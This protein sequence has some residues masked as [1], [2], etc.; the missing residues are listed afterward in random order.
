M[1]RVFVPVLPALFAS[2]GYDAVSVT[3][4]AVAEVMV[5]LHE[6][7][8]VDVP[9]GAKAQV[10]LADIEPDPVPETVTIPVGAYP[11]TVILHVAV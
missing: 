2:P 10:A 7:I 3:D 6:L 11:L 4:P 9:N 5:A 1:V 8:V